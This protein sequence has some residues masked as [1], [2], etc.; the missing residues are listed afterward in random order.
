MGNSVSETLRST[1]LEEWSHIESK[2]N[3]ADLKTLN[4]PVY[5][6]DRQHQFSEILKGLDTLKQM[7]YPVRESVDFRHHFN[8]IQDKVDAIKDLVGPVYNV[9]HN[10]AFQDFERKLFDLS[11]TFYM[12]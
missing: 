3:I 6:I 9:D 10:N 11:Q 5:S 4:Y 12:I 8:E 1:K 7:N 2:K